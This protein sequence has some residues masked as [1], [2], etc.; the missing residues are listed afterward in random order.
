[1]KLAVIYD[2]RTG[3]TR[4]AAEWIAEGMRE[5][6]DTESRIFSIQ[7]TDADYIRDCRGVVI[8]SPSY[9]ALLTAELR[10]WLLTG[11]KQM[12]LAGK[13]GGAFATEQY[14]HG[15][16]DIVIQSILTSEMVLGMLCY[17]GGAS[18]GKP[19]IH[20]GPVGVN[21]NMEA[22]NRL[23]LYKDYFRI[24]GKRFAEKAACLKI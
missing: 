9:G 5:A 4:Q 7:E 18:L 20:L 2:S 10:E 17:S 22:H 1:M 21:N 24:Y 19:V 16:G 12:N 3:N 14:T 6:E 15:G 11:A 23:D 8:G 13:L